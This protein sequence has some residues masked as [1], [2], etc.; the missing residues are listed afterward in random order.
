MAGSPHDRGQQRGVCYSLCRPKS[1]PQLQPA[2]GGEFQ[3]M[4]VIM[5]LIMLFQ[6]SPF[7]AC[8]NAI[9][10]KKIC[11]AQIRKRIILY[12]FLTCIVGVS[13]FWVN[14]CDVSRISVFVLNQFNGAPVE[15]AVHKD[16]AHNCFINTF[17]QGTVIQVYCVLKTVTQYQQPLLKLDCTKQVSQ[18]VKQIYAF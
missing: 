8:V 7:K 3:K 11:T 18:Y 9:S 13:R 12:H 15:M 17:L 1:L 6:K 14:D 16:G 4:A 5:L 10:K 2:H